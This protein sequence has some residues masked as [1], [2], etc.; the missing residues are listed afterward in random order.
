MKDRFGNEV[1]VGDKVYFIDHVH[2]KG[3]GSP[4]LRIGKIAKV[5]PYFGEHMATLEWE[6]YGNVFTEERKLTDIAKAYDG[7]N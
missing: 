7:G 1:N 2:G 3:Y 4:Y 6:G 5:E